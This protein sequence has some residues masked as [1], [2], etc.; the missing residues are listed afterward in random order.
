M[1]CSFKNLTT[2]ENH[3]MTME[4]IDA[5]FEDQGY[6]TF[7]GTVQLA[8]IDED[9]E[10]AE[11]EQAL[12]NLTGVLTKRGHRFLKHWSA[13]FFVYEPTEEPPM[14]YY[15]SHKH[16]K[17]Q[18][19]VRGTPRNRARWALTAHPR[20]TRCAPAAHP[21]LALCTRSASAAPS[22]RL[23]C[24]AKTA[25]R[26]RASSGS[27]CERARRA[28]EGEEGETGE[29]GEE[30]EFGFQVSLVAERGRGV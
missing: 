20:R 4:D 26:R 6:T 11:D 22:T 28:A 29:E 21:L 5:L 23:R 7:E 14:K 2:G 9:A 15:D 16:A 17:E 18:S 27:R 19:E 3:T 30:S 13:R 12:V 10:M 8:T 24:R 1:L 25:T